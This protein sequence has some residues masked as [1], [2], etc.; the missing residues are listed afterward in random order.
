VHR[1]LRSRG[2]FQTHTKKKEVGGMSPCSSRT[3]TLICAGAVVAALTAT[4]QTS[5]ASRAP[6]SA[7]RR[8]IVTAITESQEL[9][10]LKGSFTVRRIRISTVRTP[11]VRWGRAFTV[12][13]PGVN[14]EGARV[15]VGRFGRGWRL[16]DIGTGGAGCWLE[17]RVRR[18]LGIDDCP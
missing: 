18:D 5:L 8:N 10:P 9:A 3:R 16:V 1:N 2:S 6:S 13:K 12:P 15:I 7:E 14:R 11:S 17:A 4:A